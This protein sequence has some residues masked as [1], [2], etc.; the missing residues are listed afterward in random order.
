M[1]TVEPV[2]VSATSTGAVIGRVA[3]EP[4]G[5]PFEFKLKVLGAYRWMAKSSDAGR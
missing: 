4:D 3:A 1:F 5:W 2:S